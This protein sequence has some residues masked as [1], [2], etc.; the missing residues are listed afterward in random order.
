[1]RRLA[2][3]VC[4]LAIAVVST[5]VVGRASS[6]SAAADDLGSGQSS[7]LPCG[8]TSGATSTP[9]ESGGVVTSIQVAGLPIT[10]AGA[11][12]RVT[13]KR[14]NGTVSGSGQAVVGAT[15]SVTIGLDLPRPSPANAVT[16]AFVLRGGTP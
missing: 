10:C 12:I 16:A 5:A 4:V 6:T 7:V 14:S 9:V 11:S 3:F 13:T 15:G 2:F 1:M 8:S